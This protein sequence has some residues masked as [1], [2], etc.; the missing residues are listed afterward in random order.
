MTFEQWMEAVDRETQKRSPVSIHDL[1][2]QPFWDQWN[3]GT[4]P[5][6]MAEMALEDAGWDG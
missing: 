6:E 5:A 1:P 4:T 3:D 2:D